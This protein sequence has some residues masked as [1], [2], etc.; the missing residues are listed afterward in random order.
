MPANCRH[1]IAELSPNISK[2]FD[3]HAL[4]FEPTYTF[5]HSMRINDPETAV[6]VMI[7]A[8]G[9][10]ARCLEAGCGKSSSAGFPMSHGGGR[11]MTSL[12]F[13]MNMAA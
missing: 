1:Y 8:L 5:L 7:G 11:P 6:S 4:P 10:R 2:L 3:G 9:Y 12:V 13:C